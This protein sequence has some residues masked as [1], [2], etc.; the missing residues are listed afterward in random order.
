MPKETIYGEEQTALD[1]AGNEWPLK[2]IPL[3][4]EVRYVQRG[5][6]VHWGKGVDWV[7]VG[8][9]LTDSGS[10]DR[11]GEQGAFTMLDQ[12]ALARLIKTLQRAGRQAFGANP[13]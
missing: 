13:W 4:T 10:G 9:A 1:D 8:V 7:E 12:A 3:D 5:V 6:A 2:E 11:I